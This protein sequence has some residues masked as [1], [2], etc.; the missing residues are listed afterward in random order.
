[1][2]AAHHGALIADAFSMPVHWYYDRNA[3]DRDYPDLSDFCP[4]L[5]HHPDSILWRSRHDAI[6]EKADILHGEQQFWG[7]KGVHYHKNLQAGENT[8]NFKLARILYELI[9]D[10]KGYNPDHWLETY[11]EKML[12]PSW[13]RDTY[14]EEYHRAFFTRYASGKP[15]R[16]CGIK[17]EHIGGLATVPALV[18]GLFSLGSDRE[19]TKGCVKRHVALT[20]KHAN[21]LRAADC[22]TR[23]LFD[24]QE[25]IPLREAIM[26]SAGDWFSTKKSLKYE[27]R[28]DRDIVGIIY[29]SACYIDQSFPASLYLAWKYH[30]SFDAAIVANA[31]VGGD[32]CH[33][34][35][36]VG[37]LTGMTSLTASQLI[38]SRFCP[39][40]HPSD[41][42]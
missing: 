19:T 9:V 3:L 18:A 34:G 2:L 30:D 31:R 17:D 11:V 20:H 40:T 26:R 25:G 38:K 5:S 28:P 8:V 21:V 12:T 35:A 13:H 15:L 27:A 33:R 16:K 29:S 23:L 10:Q 14:V 39:V 6:N 1:M 4:P 7:Q 36:V 32:N 22:L 24:L 37:A 41:C 42:P